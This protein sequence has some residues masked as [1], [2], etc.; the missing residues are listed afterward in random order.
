MQRSLSIISKIILI[1]KKIFFWLKLQPDVTVFV[2][3]FLRGKNVVLIDDS[4][5]R[6]NNSRRAKELLLSA[7]VKKIYLMNY[8][9]RIG[10]IGKDGIKRGCMFGVD[11]PVD[12]DFVV[13][14]ADGKKNRTS[15]E[16]SKELGMET[17]F[18]SAEGLFK[19]FERLG[20]DRKYL[21]S[22]CIGGKYP[23]E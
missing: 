12:D 5:I 2:F 16:I 4:T 9:P 20:I 3:S 15:E 10:V 19:V 11:M 7:G 22:F 21:C 14:T 1:Y 18:L 13:R 23:F 8:T 6:G 17:F